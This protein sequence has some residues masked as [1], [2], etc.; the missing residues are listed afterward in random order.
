MKIRHYK[1]LHLIIVIACAAA[2]LAGCATQ[3][4]HFKLDQSLQKDIRILSG[5]EYLPLAKVCS[6]YG[7]DCKWDAIVRTA[8]IQKGH[9]SITLMADSGRT[10]VNGEMV[11]LGRPA[12]MSGGALLVPLSFVKSNLSRMAGYVRPEKIPQIEGPKRFAIKSIVIDPGHGGKDPGAI[13]RRS[14]SKEKDLTLR[15]ARKLRD[16]LQDTGIR[17]IMTRDS[18]VFIPLQRRSQI[19]N[20]SGADLFVSVHINA[21]RTRSLNGFECYYL[22]NA[23]DDNARAL[24]AFEN[25]SLRMN[26]AASAEHSKLLDKTLWDM[27]LTENRIESAELASYI[28][29]SVDSSFV[30]GNRGIRSARFYVLKYTNI[31][32]VLVEAGYLSNKYEEMKLKDSAFLE[33]IAESVADG[34]LKYKIEYE[35]TEGFT[36][37]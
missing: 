10:L 37:A 5:T 34:I 27:A 7:L 23:T 19:A 18:D 20:K 2:L 33:R 25:S 26:E 13:G 15:M 22:S 9:D 36:K 29:D 16:I 30:M 31:P 24:E 3:A 12:T 11:K 17:V 1:Y 14:R 21:S 35:K 6:F 4:S 32:A 28:C 8:T